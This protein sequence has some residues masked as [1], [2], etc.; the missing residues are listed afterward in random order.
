M[1]VQALDFDGAVEDLWLRGPNQC[2]ESVQIITGEFVSAGGLTVGSGM[3]RRQVDCGS[4]TGRVPL[5]FGVSQ[6]AGRIRVRV[7]AMYEPAMG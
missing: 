5:E 3:D 7:F 4:A 2:E 1:L 6:G